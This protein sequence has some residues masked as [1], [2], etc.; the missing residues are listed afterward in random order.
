MDFG[1][2]D[3]LRGR[4]WEAVDMGLWVRV[5]DDVSVDTV[6]ESMG[7]KTEGA[8]GTFKS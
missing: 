1:G 8:A 7:V 2:D 3:D 5:M 6:R 4:G